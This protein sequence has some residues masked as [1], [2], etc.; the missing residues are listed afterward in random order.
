MGP[1]G[2]DAF[3]LKIATWNVNSIRIRLE[4]LLGVLER[5]QLDVLC[6]QELKAVEEQ[7]PFEPLQEAGYFAAVL[8]QRT[9]N[10]QV[11]IFL[12]NLRTVPRARL[13]C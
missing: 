9:Y 1:G 2:R 5:H 6:L 4:R 10:G 7:F 12:S 8:G 13:S 11:L 3:D